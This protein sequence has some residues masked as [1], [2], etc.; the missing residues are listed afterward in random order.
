MGRPRKKEIVKPQE[1]V[2][3]PAELELSE[4]LNG[5]LESEMLGIGDAVAKI[6]KATGIDKLVKFV[7]GE[8]C[9]CDERRATLNNLWRFRKPQCMLEAE[10]NF[11]KE[12]IESNRQLIDY[13]TRNEIY[14]IYNRIFGTKKKPNSCGTCMKSMMNDLKTIYNTYK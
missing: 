7:A 4:K 5:D 12:L 6:T 1:Q 10:Y 13:K 2:I 11:L 9:G 8:D 14:A 3:E